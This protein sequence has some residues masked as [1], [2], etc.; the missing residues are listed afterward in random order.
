MGKIDDDKTIGPKDEPNGEEANGEWKWHNPTEK[1]QQKG[2]TNGKQPKGKKWT[3]N[4][5]GRG[6]EEMNE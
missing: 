2:G 6:E 3:E 4:K 5:S 1:K